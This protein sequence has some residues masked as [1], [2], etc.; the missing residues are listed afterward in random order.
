MFTN[1]TVYQAAVN[2]DKTKVVLTEVTGREIPAGNAVVLKST[3]DAITLTPATT[4]QT[5]TGNELLGTDVDLSTP[6]NA[7][8]L[9]RETTRD[10]G[11]TPRGIGFYTYTLTTIPA[12][13][14]YLV[15][16]G[17]PATSRGFLGFGEDDNTTAIQAHKAISDDA[18]GTIYDLSGRRIM[19]QPQKGIYV[20]NGKKFV[21]K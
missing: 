13:K 19:G 6:S 18:D 4:T 14:S 11:L 1:T 3:S 20:K 16:E 2:G 21:I 17:G 7:Y 8:C 10:G 5:L 12:H 15:V 9:S